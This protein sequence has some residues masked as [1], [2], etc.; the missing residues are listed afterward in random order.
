[1]RVRRRGGFDSSR[2]FGGG[3]K[4]GLHT[5][6][7]ARKS[8]IVLG[9]LVF[10]LIALCAGFLLNLWG[11]PARPYSIP[12]VD[13]SF[14][15][16]A[17]VRES[18]AELVRKK[19]D[20]SDYDC[21]ACHERGKP[22][23]IRYD[24]NHTIIIPKEHANLVMGHGRH[25]RNNNCFNCHNEHNLEQFQTRDGRELKFAES[26]ALCGSCHGPTYRDWEAGIHGRTSGHWARELG[27]Y[28]RR[29]CVECH[30]PHAPKFPGRKP[31]PGPHPLHRVSA[32][33]L[34]TKQN[35]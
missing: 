13:P 16:T 9:I 26:T 5:M 28:Q 33:S 4:W 19:E 21:Y 20:M 17:P 31:A 3:R 1:M 18:Y 23:P 6:N 30:D 34:E 2:G 10:S 8:S 11:R 22:P 24:T 32:A 7:D 27:A 25:E 15:D 12:L 29:D 14:L 35:H